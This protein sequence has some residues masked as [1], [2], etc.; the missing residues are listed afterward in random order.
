MKDETPQIPSIMKAR[1][2]VILLDE[3][4]ICKDFYIVGLGGINKTW[5]SN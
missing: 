5:S 4:E 3:Q 1:Q 2:L